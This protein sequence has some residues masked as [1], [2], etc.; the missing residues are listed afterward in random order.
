MEEFSRL[1]ICEY[2]NVRFII[3]TIKDMVQH[4]EALTNN[5]DQ[6]P[7]ITGEKYEKNLAY[8]SSDLAVA[9]S[10]TVTLELARV[11]LPAIVIYKTSVITYALVKFLIKTPWICLINILAKKKVVP[12]L[13]Q[14]KCSGETIFACA[15]K[16]LSSGESEKQ[17]KSFKKIIEILKTNPRLAAMEILGITKRDLP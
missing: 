2:A 17:R 12:E 8:Y 4:I 11:G 3:P 1:M 6:K 5:W 15:K 13:L 7:L 10:G 9:A 14:N 16:I